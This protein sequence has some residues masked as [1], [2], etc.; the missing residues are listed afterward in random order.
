MNLLADPFPG[1]KGWALVRGV[2][3]YYGYLISRHPLT[4]AALASNLQV[5]GVIPLDQ[6]QTCS[7]LQIS[8]FHCPECEN[9]N[10][11]MTALQEVINSRNF[12]SI[13]NLIQM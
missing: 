8:T 3:R 4:V 11:R 1:E 13:W 12:A 9:E 6:S 2:D 7:D 10:V 5:T